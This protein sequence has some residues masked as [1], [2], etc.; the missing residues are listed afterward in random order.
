[1][2]ARLVGGVTRLKED[3]M[4]RKI[5]LALVTGLALLLD[6]RLRESK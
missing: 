3:A 2:L 5:G 1:M 4:K 6:R